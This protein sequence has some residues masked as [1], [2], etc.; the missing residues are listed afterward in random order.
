MRLHGDP[1]LLQRPRIYTRTG[2]VQGAHLICGG[3][4]RVHSLR[5]FEKPFG[6]AGGVVVAAKNFRVCFCHVGSFV[7]LE[8]FGD[9]A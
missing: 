2:V 4:L 5:V 3:K 6:A 1:Q 8:P 7:G 9:L